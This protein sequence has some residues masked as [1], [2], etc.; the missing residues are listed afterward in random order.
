MVQMGGTAMCSRFHLT[1]GGGKLLEQIPGGCG[2]QTG[3]AHPGDRIPV[4]METGKGAEIRTMIW[5]FR[6][7]EKKTLIFQAR[8]E[9]VEEK[10]LFRA[11]F[12]GFRCAVPASWFYEWNRQRE[13][14]KFE[15][16][17]PGKLL[18]LAGIWRME[19]DGP[20]AVILTAEA[21]GSVRTVHDRMPLILKETEL[22]AWC[23]DRDHARML[24]KK[25]PPDL[26]KIMEYEQLSLI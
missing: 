24:L 4:F 13:K 1:A 16:N 8:S 12:S 18:W 6:M 14:A 19:E 22:K 3:E 21:A 11:A 17:A 15:G 23:T 7:E 25:T 2:V 20:H 5:G 10:S 9:S 26:K